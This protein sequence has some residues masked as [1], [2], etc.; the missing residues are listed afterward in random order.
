MPFGALALVAYWV[1]FVFPYIALLP[2][3]RLGNYWAGRI[4]RLVGLDEV[5]DSYSGMCYLA[6]AMQHFLPVS[7]LALDT[8][9]AWLQFPGCSLFIKVTSG[10]HLDELGALPWAGAGAHGLKLTLPTGM[11]ALTGQ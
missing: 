11:E 2:I 8:C 5:G 7:G 9:E 6:S 1:Q 10:P 4:G 3:S